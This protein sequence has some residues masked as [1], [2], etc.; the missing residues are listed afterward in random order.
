MRLLMALAFAIAALS[1]S[2][3]AQAQG[4]YYPWCARY[5][6]WTIVCGFDSYRQCMATVI[7]EGGICQQNVA[8]PPFAA[9]RSAKRKSRRTY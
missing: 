8:P 7:G 3:A 4:K 2:P 1:V 5:D 9:A 6:A